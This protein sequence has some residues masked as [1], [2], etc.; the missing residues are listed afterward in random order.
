MIFILIFY[1]V[2]PCPTQPRS[3]GLL[4]HWIFDIDEREA[5]DTIVIDILYRYKD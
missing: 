4:A 3:Q 1:D 5:A 2:I